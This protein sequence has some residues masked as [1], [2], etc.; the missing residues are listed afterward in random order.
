VRADATPPGWQLGGERVTEKAA[1]VAASPNKTHGVR[2]VL[3][4]TVLKKQ[5]WVS[6]W[7]AF[8]CSAV[9]IVERFHI[10]PE[11]S[12]FLFFETVV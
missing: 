5:S 9:A 4:S 12:S 3:Y 1:M 11:L 2:V 6:S 7:E 8:S 10:P